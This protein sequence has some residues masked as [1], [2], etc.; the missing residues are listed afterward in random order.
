M[1]LLS[2]LPA[3]FGRYAELTLAFAARDLRIRYRQT[4]LGVLWVM[5]QPLGFVMLMAPIFRNLLSPVAPPFYP[6]FV[7]SGLVPWFFLANSL[8]VATTSLTGNAT[9]LTKVRF[10]RT[11]L[12]VACVLSFGLDLGIGWTLWFALAVVSG[13]PLTAGVLWMIPLTLLQA[14]FVTGLAVGCAV[15]NARNGEAGAA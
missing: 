3:A 15:G 14:L 12:P 9:L 2:F 11:S 1:V 4:L 10:P 7:L 13:I 6:L 5:A 8:S